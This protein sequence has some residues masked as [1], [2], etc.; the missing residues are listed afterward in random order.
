MVSAS[1]G[2]STT[3][4]LSPTGFPKFLVIPRLPFPHTLRVVAA[5]YSCSSLG[6]LSVLCLVSH[7][8]LT[9]H[10]YYVI[11]LGK[12]LVHFCFTDWILTDTVLYI[13]PYWYIYSKDFIIEMAIIFHV[14]RSPPRN[15]M[16]VLKWRLVSKASWKQGLYPFLFV[17]SR[18]QVQVYIA[19]SPDNVGNMMALCV[20][21]FGSKYFSRWISFA[22]I[23]LNKM[24]DIVFLCFPISH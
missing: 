13:L 17:F 19:Y 14:T 10:P 24:N 4:N 18:S 8:H 23:S 21:M 22:V 15:K 7:H 9:N 5:S 3:M 6:A 11:Y 16:L 20:W 12:N 1:M 2:Q